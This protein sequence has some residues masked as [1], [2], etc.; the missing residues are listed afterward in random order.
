MY[1][2]A[3]LYNEMLVRVV[4]AKQECSLTVTGFGIGGLNLRQKS[5]S[6]VR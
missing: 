6:T 5:F 1:C 2:T 4:L 3:V